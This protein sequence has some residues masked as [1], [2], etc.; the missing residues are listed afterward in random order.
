MNELPLPL[1]LPLPIPLPADE[2]A[3]LADW[4]VALFAGDS[5]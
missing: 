2:V 1:P 4:Q 3:V 5:D